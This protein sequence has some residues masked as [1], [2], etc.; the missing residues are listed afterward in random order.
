[1]LS[2]FTGRQPPQDLAA[3][4]QW[5]DSKTSVAVRVMAVAAALA[6]AFAFQGSR[7]LYEPDEGRYVDIALEMERL[8]DPLIPHLHHELPH[9][10]KPPLTYWLI[11]ASFQLL[12]RNEWAARTP[13]ALAFLATV[14]L[15]VGLGRRL[16]P[17]AGSRPAFIY[18]TSMMPFVAVSVV[19]ADTLLTLWETLAVYGFAELWWGRPERHRRGCGLMWLGLALSFLTKGP[20]GLLPL[21]A[22]VV[23][24][25]LTGQRARLRSLFSFTGL[26]VFVL[27]GCSWY[28]YVIAREPATLKYFLG[29]EVVDR[30]LS[31]VHGR[32]PEWYGAIKVYL[33]AFLIGSLPWTL[34]L[35]G[36]CRE[37]WSLLRGGR[38]RPLLDRDPRG[39]FLLIWILLPLVVFVFARSRLEFY[40]LPL[41]G[42]L[43]LVLG[44]RLAAS[45]FFGRRWLTWLAVWV[46]V[47]VG[48]RG[49]AGWVPHHKDGR[50]LAAALEQ[51]V[52]QPIDEV[53]FVETRPHYGLSF[54]LDAEVEEVSLYSTEPVRGQLARSES[55][56]E[57]LGEEEG[58]RVFALTEHHERAFRN[59]CRDLGFAVSR[60]GGWREL[61]FFIVSGSSLEASPGDT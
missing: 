8:G 35:L 32:N 41:F 6:V 52:P 4:S 37:G 46:T 15:I 2:D 1:M 55:L 43:A 54:Y 44:R 18:A 34:V 25:L 24:G 28:L 17:E 26:I 12:G 51:A 13:N 58:T 48:L 39:A 47:L 19:N 5:L 3:S 42:P 7:G 31:D 30:V 53:A 29:Y 23:F 49:V 36:A 16:A 57:E 10:A 27:V 22:I 33:P 56:E 11:D 45:P 38:W 59:A 21:V 50:L 60:V 20:P 40:V 14:L 61:G 9:L